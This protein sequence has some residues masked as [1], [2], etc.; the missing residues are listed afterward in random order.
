MIS[1]SDAHTRLLP[2]AVLVA[3]VLTLAAMS[4]SSSK[5]NLALVGATIYASP[6]EEPIRDGVV[7]IQ[8]GKIAAVGI[9]GSVR[10][11]EDFQTVDCSGL[12]IAAG[13]WNSHVHFFER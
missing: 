8:N 7:L 1:R 12:T 11:P 9:R 2:R 10:V 6:T 5:T 4:Q 3:I 13:F